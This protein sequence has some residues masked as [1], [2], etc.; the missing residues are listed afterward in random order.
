MC[1]RDRNKFELKGSYKSKA[2]N[3]ISLGAFNIPKGSVKVIAGGRLLREGIDY[4]VNYQ[5][6]RLRILDPS[7]NA[8]NIPLKITV[9]NN[10]V[11]GQQNKRFSGFTVE[12]KIND[13]FLIGGTYM[14]LSERPITQKS[15]YGS[16][17]VN[18]T[19]IGFNAIFSKDI[20]FLTRMVNK[21]PNIDTQSASNIS[22]RAEAAYLNVGTPKSNK[23]NDVA[24]AY[25]DDFEGT[26]TNL[27]IRDTSSWTLSSVPATSNSI[28]LQGSGIENNDLSAGFNRAKLA[29]YNIDPIFYSRKRPSGISDDDLST[30]ETR[31]I[32][33]N[34]VFPQQDVVQG[35]STIQ[36]TLDLAYY[37]D[38][39]G[40][41]NNSPNFGDNPENNW[42]GI[43]RAMTTTNFNQSSVEHL[44][45]IHI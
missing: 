29:W 35:Q 8:S 40:P 31:R 38:E 28:P 26:Q 11:F 32:F 15:N 27:D 44:S 3:G 45:L 22:V 10:S 4:T 43:T 36:Y 14:R 9:E 5:I 41:Y 7:I 18:N 21:L 13:D 37:P 12:H 34:E 30:N 17:P 23:L 1:I 33:I 20:P 42:A 19:M 2:G 16:E 25:I 6:G 24:T 39:K